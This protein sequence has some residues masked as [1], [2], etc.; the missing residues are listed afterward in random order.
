MSHRLFYNLKSKHLNDI[1]ALIFGVSFCVLI[2]SL[3]F[4][5]FVDRSI[6]REDNLTEISGKI[7][8]VKNNKRKGAVRS[9]RF[10][11]DGKSEEYGYFQG[12]YVGM[13]SRELESRGAGEVV[14]LVDLNKKFGNKL[15]GYFYEAYEIRHSGEVIVSYEQTSAAQHKAVSSVD[16]IAPFSVVFGSIVAVL[17]GMFL[18]VGKNKLRYYP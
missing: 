3:I 12:D 9:V 4:V 2:A 14:I 6:E 1:M 13:V 8:G 7:Y 5:V 10:S 18:I 16:K 17:S 15:V 11:L